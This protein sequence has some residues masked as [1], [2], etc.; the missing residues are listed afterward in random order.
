MSE[1]Q[2]YEFEAVDQRL[3]PTQQAELR[4]ISTRAEISATRFVNTYNYGDFG[5]DPEALMKSHFDLH[6]YLANWGTRRLMLRL[7]RASIDEAAL[8]AVLGGCEASQL[9]P[10]GDHVVL[11]LLRDAEGEDDGD[12]RDDGEWLP[13]LAPLREALLEGD[14]RLAYLAWLSEV[15]NGGIDETETEPL[16]GLGPLD[17]AMKAF[18]DFFSIDPDLLTA[19][20]ERAG[21]Q[22]AERD[23]AAE[24]ASLPPDERDDWLVRLHE[25]EPGLSAALR[26][27]LRPSRPVA[28]TAAELPRRS[29]GDLLARAEVV[30]TERKK[31]EAVEAEK[32]RRRLAEAQERQRVLRVAALASRGEDA[33]REVETE[34]ERRSAPGYERAAA[35]LADLLA[36]AQ[37]D[38]TLPAF[39]KRLA[40]IRVRHATKR[41]FIERLDAIPNLQAQRFRIK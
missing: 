39:E 24:I 41:R 7:P 29:A 16:A 12:D 8:G 32:V 11:D 2:Y 30:E 19:A 22:K 4:A 36:L 10:A 31:A 37:R 14:F 18:A 33:W 13:A 35:L 9:R 1:H 38:G 28:E 6:L 27:R 40:A 15:S 34:V 21:S 17:A 5:G 25:N 23:P 20:A 26:A 3:T